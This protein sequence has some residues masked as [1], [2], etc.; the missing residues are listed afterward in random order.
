MTPPPSRADLQSDHRCGL[1]GDLPDQDRRGHGGGLR[2]GRHGNGE[3]VS[4]LF[5]RRPAPPLNVVPG[6]PVSFWVPVCLIEVVRSLLLP[7]PGGV[8]LS[9]TI[10]GFGSNTTT[11]S[12]GIHHAFYPV[13]FYAYLIFA[14]QFC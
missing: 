4:R 13:H 1:D 3:Q 12:H 6:I 14:S 11:E 8:D 2:T 5:L 7:V 10:Q 9:P